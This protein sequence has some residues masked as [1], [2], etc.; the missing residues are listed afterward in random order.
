M[1]NSKLESSPIAT[2]ILNIYSLSRKMRGM[3]RT[4]EFEKV[5]GALSR[6]KRLNAA[7]DDIFGIF[8][9]EKPALILLQLKNAGQ[10]LYAS[11]LAKDIDCTYSHVNFILQK[12]EDNRLIEF[13]RQGRL[14]LLKLT[15]R[16]H[17]FADFVERA[18]NTID[19]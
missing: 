5:G 1:T 9:R 12:M 17:E 8:F 6:R 10:S 16:G 14:K 19:N 7:G 11:S 18:R 3:E 15:D 2:I 4:I 13:E